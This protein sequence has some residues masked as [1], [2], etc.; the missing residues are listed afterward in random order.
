[1]DHYEKLKEA[2]YFAQIS[3]KRKSDYVDGVFSY[4]LFSAQ[5][6]KLCYTKDKYGS[7]GEKLAFKGFHDTKDYLTLINISNSKTVELLTENSLY[8][9]LDQLLME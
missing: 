7:L 2:G 3:G 6:L 5:K 4:G 9:G 1:M 8:H